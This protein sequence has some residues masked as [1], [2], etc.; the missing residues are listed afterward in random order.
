MFSVGQHSVKVDTKVSRITCSFNHSSSVVTAGIG[1][2]P[3]LLSSV[4]HNVCALCGLMKD[5]VSSH[6]LDTLSRCCTA[7]A[8]SWES[9]DVLCEPVICQCEKLWVQFGS[10]LPGLWCIDI[11]EAW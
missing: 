4:H 11:E 3:V 6:Y 1:L 2:P 8:A 7:S 9:F 5:P 10:H